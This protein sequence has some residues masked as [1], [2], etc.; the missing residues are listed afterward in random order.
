MSETESR[1][2][3][4]CGELEAQVSKA[5]ELHTR[6]VA[7]EQR[8]NEIQKKHDEYKRYQ[9]KLRDERNRLKSELEKLKSGSMTG[10]A[11]EGAEGSA[12]TTTGGSSVAV[13]QNAQNGT[14]TSS[15]PPDYQTLYESYQT[16]YQVSTEPRARHPWALL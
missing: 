11:A 3:K 13:P 12:V 10:A 9:L 6:V 15:A 14:G 7:A 4:K 8:A 5:K 1:Y 16:K 2:K